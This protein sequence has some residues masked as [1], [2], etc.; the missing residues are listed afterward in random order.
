LKLKTK[1]CFLL[2]FIT[3]AVFSVTGFAQTF[4]VEVQIKNQPAGNIIFGSV[5]GDEFTP[6]DSTSLKQSVGKITF[7]FP[8]NAH[9]GVYR[10]VFGLSSAAK[11]LKEPPQQ[12]DFIFDNENLVFDTD[13]KDPVE[14][15]KVIQSKEN[16][17]WF[18]F[19]SR[20]KLIRKNIELLGKQIDQYWLKGDT[21]KVIEMANEFNQLQ[22]ESDLMVVQT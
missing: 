11:I 13:F 10:I 8:E 12:L 21:A 19:L 4:K 7:T 20:D 3:L 2:N 14:N 9:T 6:I 1:V 18:D 5:K 17:I 16:T 22:M 15:L